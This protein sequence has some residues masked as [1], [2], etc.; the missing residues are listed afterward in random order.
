MNKTHLNVVIAI[1]GDEVLAGEVLDTN[2]NWLAKQLFNLG[3]SLKR[4]IVLPDNE[5]ILLNELALL[6]NNYDLV[7]TTG[8]IGPTCDDITIDVIAKLTKRPLIYNPS[9]IDAMNRIRPM[10]LLEGRKKM[11]TLPKDARLLYS[12]N[13]GAPGFWVDNIIV[14]PGIPD[15]M[16]AMFEAIM[17][18]LQSVPYFRT[19]IKSNLRESELSEAMEEVV[20]LFPEIKIGSYPK[21]TEDGYY[22]L[23]VLRGENE[24]KVNEAKDLLE[25]KLNQLI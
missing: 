1:I 7:I 21:K 24:S 17:P 9:I 2:S 16:K 23:L 25:N 18:E 19:E 4:I 13:S 10:P 11:A 12:H 15:I 20:G 8:G 22:V 6:A 3:H 5:Q 14:L